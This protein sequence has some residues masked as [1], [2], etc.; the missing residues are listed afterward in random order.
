ME[1]LTKRRPT[2]LLSTHLVLKG[3]H[4]LMV[5]EHTEIVGAL[6]GAPVIVGAAVGGVV[7]AMDVGEAVGTVGEEVG[8][9]GGRVAAVGMLGAGVGGVGAAV[10]AEV[11]T[12]LKL[13][14]GST[15]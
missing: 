8:T 2:L 6:V 13:S 12:Q 11:V 3:S 15:T 10:G 1:L 5:V 14:S 4:K 9:V 7:G